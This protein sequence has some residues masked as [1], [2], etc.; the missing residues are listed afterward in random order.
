MEF[1]RRDVTF[2]R[3]D[4][5]WS[6]TL[7][8]RD[9][10]PHVAT[11]FGHV[12]CHVVTWDSNVAT[13][14]CLLFVTSRC[15]PARRDV[16]LFLAQERF[17]FCPSPPTPITRNPSLLAFLL[18][19]ALPELSITPAGGLYIAFRPTLCFLGCSSNTG[20][21]SL[22]HFHHVGSGLA[23]RRSQWSRSLLDSIVGSIRCSFKVFSI[24]V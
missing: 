7:P 3:R 15:D 12:L 2:T 13:W 20:S 14:A 16:A 24:I 1:S 4:V 10:A 21:G 9:V 5:I 23:S 22:W 18:S 6:L 17:I 11:S 19:L 8:R